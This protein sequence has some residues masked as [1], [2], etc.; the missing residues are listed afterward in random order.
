MTN[1]DKQRDSSNSKSTFILESIA[2]N[3][4]LLLSASDPDEVM[5]TVLRNLGETADVSRA[6]IFKNYTIDETVYTSQKF[7]WVN[8]GIT[9]QIEDPELQDIPLSEAGYDRWIEELSNDNIICGN[10]EDFPESEKAMLEPQDIISILVIPIMLNAGLWG[11]IGFDCCE[12]KRLWSEIEIALL[13]TTAA[14]LG[15]ALERKSSEKRLQALS[16]TSFEAT[17]IHEQG[18]CIGQNLT[19][20]KMF[21]YADEEA[22]GR[23]GTEWIVPGDREKVMKYLLSNSENPHTVTALRKDGATF[24]AEIQCKMMN[25]HGRQVKFMALRDITMSAQY[26]SSLRESEK[27]YRRSSSLFRLLADNMSDLLWA[28]DMD[29]RIIFANKAA[30]DKMLNAEDV[31]EPV[32]KKSIFFVERENNSHPD[33]P[34]WHTF[35]KTC[36]NSD[37]IVIES[38]KAE[39]FN[40]FGN[41]KGKFLFLDVHK[42]P[43]R[44]EEGR[45]IGIVGSARDVTHE[46][47]LESEREKMIQALQAGGNFLTEAQEL[48][49]IGSWTKDLSTGERTWSKEMFKIVGFELQLVTDELLDSIFYPGDHEKFTAQVN[50]AIEEHKKVVNTEYQVQRP[51]GE[52]RHVH[53][54]IRIE[55]DEEWKPLKYFGTLQDITLRVRMENEKLQLE[56]QVLHSQKLESLG[57]LAGGIA[58]DFNNIL[59][60]ILGNADLALLNLSPLSPVS[61]YINNVISSTRHAAELSKQM[62]AYSGR[63]KFVVKSI[64]LNELIGEIIHLIEISVSK[65]II[66]KFDLHEKLPAIECDAAQ[67]RQVVMNLTTNASEAIGNLS[68][69]ITV[70]TGKEFCNREFIDSTNSAAWVGLEELPKEGTYVYIE[71]SDTGCGMN[72]ET[73]KKIFDPF[74]STKFTGRGLGMAALIGIVRGHSGVILIN[75]EIGKGSTIRIYFPETEKTEI[76]HSEEVS[77]L[78]ELTATG[79]ILL[80]DD[81]KTVRD[82]AGQMLERSGFS[83]ITA[84]DGRKAIE[85]FKKCSEDIDFV[86]LDYTMPYMYGVKCFYKLREIKPEIP[87][88][89]SSGFN[90][91]EISQK[92]P[93]I[94]AVGFI[95]KPYRMKEIIRSI[96]H[97]MKK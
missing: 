6:Y 17:F 82:V 38:G 72:E 74:F 88:L 46:K 58:H 20:E 37:A 80:V 59:M 79:T 7:E 61:E 87:V 44:D 31:Y 70:S 75:T 71:V 52:I 91:Q 50:K 8:R 13:R 10:V 95:Q 5:D 73:L 66:L 42:A 92:L 43:L 51:D 4:R 96:N 30:C 90:K 78:T 62:L 84:V 41:V 3:A 49:H 35:G 55:Y 68:G 39:Q 32:G 12:S 48:A 18:M 21:G 89:L 85:V 34:D 83:V 60:G 29:G 64:D 97:I 36:A 33:D 93:D 54:R 16:D 40:E 67:L 22:H 9:Q 69:A 25:Y 65:N 45:I 15:S 2:E 76:S 27:K 1:T 28:K 81:D 24:P 57:I 11:F 53:E 56:R 94:E 26:E 77:V 47:K 23:C 86:L 14:C 19:A 63:G